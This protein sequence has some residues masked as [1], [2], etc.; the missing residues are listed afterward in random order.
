[1]RMLCDSD[2]CLSCFA[3][4]ASCS[5]GA[6]KMHED[7]LGKLLPRIDESKCVHC[8]CCEKVCPQ[9]NPVKKN[10]P[11]QCYAGYA[12]L[13][14]DIKK[15]S[16]GGLATALGRFTLKNSGVVYGA[17]FSN[18]EF[19]YAAIT[20]T[21]TLD[22]LRG[23]KY[24]YSAA[25]KIYS[26]IKQQLNN[27]VLC[28]FIGL[29]CQ[30]AGLRTFLGKEYDNLVTVD[31]ICHGAPP[32]KYLEEYVNS[33]G[34]LGKY[35]SVMFRGE[36]N[37]FFSVVDCEGNVIYSKKQQEDRYFEAFMTGLIHRNC[38]YSCQFASSERVSDI[39]LG[40]FWGLDRNILSEYSGRISCALINTPKG[41]EIFEKVSND[42]IFIERSV[43]E[44][45]NG[46]EQLRRPSNRNPK[47][48]VF[49]ESYIK[50]GLSSALRDSSISK[51]VKYFTLK[52]KLL[53]FPRIVK[54]MLLK[55]KNR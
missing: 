35:D 10:M 39:T 27:G 40:D 20:D 51:R 16:S 18:Q 29:P 38:C 42:L 3:C 47:R 17:V 50:K 22:K 24:V 4:F 6:I 31:L 9:I 25:G 33:L 5:K 48:D 54:R 43:S 41:K 55:N 8:G 30:V 21:Q 28:T 26:D 13:D 1:M 44:A 46:N 7:E 34:L 52:N 2:K 19:S 53:Y 12:K 11:L 49:E 23:S 32:F 37:Y 45:I 36:R 15:S 14:P